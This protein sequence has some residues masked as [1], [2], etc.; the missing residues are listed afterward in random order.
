MVECSGQREHADWLYE[1]VYVLMT[2]DA[3]YDGNMT[4]LQQVLSGKASL[5]RV[6]C[7]CS[8]AR[9]AGR[10]LDVTRCNTQIFWE[11]RNFYL[12][13]MSKF[14]S[15]TS[16]FLLGATESRFVAVSRVLGWLLPSAFRLILRAV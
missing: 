2:A 8:A 5:E 16:S 15:H 12:V 11:A 1:G 4:N 10:E 7:T 3:A 6:K 13:L 9:R 14:L